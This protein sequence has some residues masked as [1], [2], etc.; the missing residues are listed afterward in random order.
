MIDGTQHEANHGAYAA[1]SA[2]DT[3]TASPTGC[4]G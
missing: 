3:A 2:V 1:N 4:T